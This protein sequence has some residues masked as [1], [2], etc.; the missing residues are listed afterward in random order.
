M[1]IRQSMTWLEDVYLGVCIGLMMAMKYFVINPPHTWTPYFFIVALL[2]PLGSCGRPLSKYVLIFASCF[3]SYY[4][5]IQA[6]HIWLYLTRTMRT[7]F[8]EQLDEAVNEKAVFPPL[9]PLR[10]LTLNSLDSSDTNAED[11]PQQNKQ[12][13]ESNLRKARHIQA[14]A[15]Q[16]IRESNMPPTRWS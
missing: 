16:A 8:K 9:Q 6:D 11:S 1:N 14:Q 5:L 12:K 3:Y 2:V 4:A 10:A 13:L 7:E 15:E